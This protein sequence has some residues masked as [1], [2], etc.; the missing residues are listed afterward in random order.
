MKTTKDGAPAPKAQRNFT[1]PESRIMTHQ[2][3]FMQ[4]YNGQVVVDGEHQIIVAHALTNQSPDTEHLPAMLDLVEVNTGAFPQ[5]LTA[6]A[7]YWSESNAAACEDRGVDAFIAT[8]RLKHGESEPPV[9]GRPPKNL[10]AKGRMW[11]RLRTKIGR[12]V[13]SRRKVIVEPC[14][15]QIKGRGFW[16]LLLRGLEKGRGEWALIATS[17]NI[18][19][20]YRVAWQAS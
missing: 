3:G 14:F 13:Y 7:G 9:R 4:G 20:Y 1:D 10:D 15:G 11:R 2:G 16:Q 18:L 5:R 6:D 12:A 17:H 19:K 8:G